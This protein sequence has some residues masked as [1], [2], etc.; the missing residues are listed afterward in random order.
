MQ[1]D[2]EQVSRLLAQRLP[3]QQGWPRAPQATQ[4]EPLQVP[5]VPHPGGQVPPHP[6]LP[7][8]LPTQFGTQTQTP[9]GPQ[10]A[11][12]WQA[13]PAQQA[14]P[15]APQLTHELPLHTVPAP[16]PGAQV[17]PQPSGPQTAPPQVGAHTQR[18]PEQVAPAPHALPSQQG[19]PIAPQV[20]H[21][22]PW[23]TDPAAQPGA[24]VPP[25][26]SGPQLLPAHEGAQTQVPPEQ[27]IPGSHPVPPQQGW[28]AAPHETQLPAAVQAAEPVHPGGQVPPQPL[29]P[30]LLPAQE[31]AHAHIPAIQLVPAL[32][33]PWQQGWPSAP[34]PV[35]CPIKSQASMLPQLVPGASVPDTVQT[36]PPEVQLIWAVRHTGPLQLAPAVQ[37]TQVP[38]DE[39]TLFVPQVVPGLSIPTSVQTGSPEV[40][41]IWAV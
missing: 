32:H 36:G 25:H 33:M 20:K 12:A 14:C 9:V 37:S 11:G 4:L 3:G 40:H 29:G 24:Q 15:G 19:W 6:S 23:H 1:V 38:T 39:Q 7:Q 27:F 31:G 8:V 5:V 17:P 41:L 26:P 2:F 34:H 22:P 30:Q 13:F 35:H 16:Q 28:P 18:P 10:V 21:A